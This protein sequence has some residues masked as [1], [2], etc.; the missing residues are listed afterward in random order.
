MMPTALALLKYSL[1]LYLACIASLPAK[2]MNH[3]V[4]QQAGFQ[5]SV[6]PRP[7]W[8]SQ[9]P[10]PK[11]NQQQDAIRDI[12][13]LL[14]ERQ[15]NALPAEA[16]KVQ[17][18]YRQVLKPQNTFGLELGSKIEIDFD[19]SYEELILH[20]V[21]INRNGQTINA[22]QADRVR[23]LQQ[24]SELSDN[25]V[26]GKLTALIYVSGSQLGDEIEYSYSIRGSNPVYK[27]RLSFVHHPDA[28][29]PIG[30]S[31][32]RLISHLN[33]PFHYQ[34]KY[35]KEP[36]VETIKHPEYLEYIYQ[37]K[38]TRPY[39]IEQ[40]VPESFSAQQ[41]IHF[42]EFSNWSQVKNWATEMYRLKQQLS[43]ELTD[44]IQS[45]KPLA[46][47]QQVISALRF[48]Q[49][50]IRYLGLEMASNSQQPHHP[51]EVFQNR[52]GDCKDKVLLFKQILNK[53]Q[54][55][56]YA[57][58]V[59]TQD[60]ATLLA[61]PLAF[62]HVISYIEL[63]GKAYWLD[64][65]QIYQQGSLEHNSYKSHNT[66]LLLGHPQLTLV[67]MPD[68]EAQQNRKEMLSHYKISN[69]QQAVDLE[70]QTQYFGQYADFYRMQLAT[71]SLHHIRQHYFNIIR[72]AYVDV[73]KTQELQIEDDE[74]NNVI[75]ITE[76]YRLYDFFKLQD[77]IY[78]Y[79]I[80]AYGV[81]NVLVEPSRA[82]RTQPFAL[83]GPSTY[84][85]TIRYYF[86]N[87]DLSGFTQANKQILG[88]KLIYTREH[89]NQNLA[90]VFSYKL[91]INSDAVQ[92]KDIEHLRYTVQDIYSD[93]YESWG[94]ESNE[95]DAQ[96][97]QELQLL[98]LLN[99][100]EQKYVLLN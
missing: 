88:P 56:A 5:F 54:I 41:I 27:N 22:L 10:H 59:N 61:S 73:A 77:D 3:K 66:A 58:L 23:L 16:F 34:S 82:P 87:S 83:D 30:L 2:A 26:N 1:I 96:Q 95:N 90:Q 65:S 69:L 31:Y 39:K 64:P 98:E 37:D 45:L 4:Y 85:H 52:H 25:I 53:L 79:D 43:P 38:M 75:S 51:N 7:T 89:D 62:N 57:A 15:I 81:N 33:R 80:D 94:I 97:Q 91:E 60:E 68:E 63:N 78:Y 99:E 12:D 47:E 14:Y 6:E 17:Q 29:V 100:L 74:Q 44:Y 24:E 28:D 70:I 50:N 8:L 32:F 40:R 84:Q 76:H 42:S 36:K 55:P 72:Q 19:P 11:A 18:Y 49:N 46:Q 13:Y 93:S 9:H 92:A 67:N 21:Q 86:Q 20:T 71:N 48:V 35:Q